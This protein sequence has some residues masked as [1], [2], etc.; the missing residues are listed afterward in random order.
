MAERAE[1]T[2]PF[3]LPKL[4]GAIKADGNPNSIMRAVDAPRGT[5][6]QVH[7]ANRTPFEARICNRKPRRGRFAGPND[8]GSIM[9]QTFN[10]ETNQVGFM[11]LG[12]GTAVRV[13]K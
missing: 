3:H 5:R 6:V 4:A 11:F 8:H 2:K 12:S 1:H 7:C 13:L 10:P 9:I